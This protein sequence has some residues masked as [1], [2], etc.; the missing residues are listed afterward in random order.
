MALWVGEPDLDGDPLMSL[1]DDIELVVR[2]TGQTIYAEPGWEHHVVVL[3]QQIRGEPPLPPM[4]DQVRN[5]LAAAG[6]V[7][8]AVVTGQPVFVNSDQKEARL[9]VCRSCDQY[10]PSDDRCGA[11]GC[12]QD[13]V[14]GKAA[15]ATESCPLGRW[16]A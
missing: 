4:A 5:A 3:A 9:A 10:R 1:Q 15:L 2:R 14:A 7:V 6:R 12:W 8:S 11:C 16:P 13:G